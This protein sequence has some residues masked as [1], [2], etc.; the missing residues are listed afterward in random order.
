MAGG[1]KAPHICYPVISVLAWELKQGLKESSR[2]PPIDRGLF[3]QSGGVQ[4]LAEPF[5]NIP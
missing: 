2:D 4:Q 5:I 3:S 1:G